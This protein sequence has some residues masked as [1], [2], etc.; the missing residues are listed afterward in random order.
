MVGQ[1]IKRKINLNSPVNQFF[2]SFLSCSLPVPPESPSLW[3]RTKI[4]V[5]YESVLKE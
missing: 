2:F 3:V 1:L 4:E 5:N